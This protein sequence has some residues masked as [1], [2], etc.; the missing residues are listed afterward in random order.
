MINKRGKKETL[1]QIDRMGRVETTVFI[2]TEDDIK[3]SWNREDTFNIKPKNLK[4]YRSVVDQGWQRLDSLE[5][6][7]TGENVQDW[8]SPHPWTALIVDDFLIVDFGAGADGS[9]GVQP[10]TTTINYL[11]IEANHYQGKATKSIG[12]RVPNENVI[13]RMLTVFINGLE[14]PE[15]SR[16]VGV[17]APDRLSQ[18][19][20]PFV[21]AP[22]K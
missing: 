17:Q 4:Q 21:A 15:P 19:G 11:N 20:F 9:Y 12:G 5:L 14:R 6:S 13:T 2:V 1:R 3:N 8:P 7:L 10:S 16:G 22:F 18:D